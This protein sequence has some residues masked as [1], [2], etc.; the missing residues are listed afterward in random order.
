MT[1]SDLSLN[2]EVFFLSQKLF[3][4]NSQTD[5]ACMSTC[6]LIPSYKDRNINRG[7]VSVVEGYQRKHMGLGFVTY[8][9]IYH[10]EDSLYFLETIAL[11]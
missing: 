9:E 11:I 8:T 10:E 7:F 3:L 1:F 2:V 4:L 6:K 5:F